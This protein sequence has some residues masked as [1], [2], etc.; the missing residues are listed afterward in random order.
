MAHGNESKFTSEMK[1]QI[2]K[3]H[4]LQKQI[5]ELT[6]KLKEMDVE[7][8]ER[9]SQLAEIYISREWKLAQ[10]FRKINTR[11]APSGSGLERMERALLS[12]LM[13]IN[14]WRNLLMLQKGH[15]LAR[16]HNRS[17]AIK[18]ETESLKIKNSHK[19]Q[20]SHFENEKQNS[21]KP[22]I[23]YVI[24][25]TAI[26]GG[27]AVICEHANRLLMRGYDVSLI[28]E[29]NF[30]KVAWFPNQRVAVLPLSQ[31]VKETY[32]ILIA[33]SWST[34][35]TTQ[36]L[37]ADRKFYFVQ[38]DESRFYS[39]RG[40]KSIWARKTYEMNFEFMTMARWIQNWLKQEFGKNS[41]YV[42]N[43]LNEQIIFPDKPIKNKRDKIRILLEGPINIPFKGME[44]AFRA[45]AG[46]DCEVWC[47]S[48]FGAPKPG[49]KCDE[50]FEK[51]PFGKMRHIY[52]SC[53]ILLKMSRIESFSYPPLEMMAC[54]GAVV[55]G[56][57]TGIDEY[58]VDGYNAL[59][60]EQGDVQGAHEALK[61]LIE[62]ESL[63]NELITNGKKTAE[64]FRWKPSIDILES[65]FLKESVK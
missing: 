62:N 4:L 63:R 41:T 58:I 43:G 56:K 15:L 8:S 12:I 61:R 18:V 29:D 11:L 22:K 26:S 37:N 31:I 16:F 3:T 49:W 14:F 60:V 38:S 9:D 6:A 1:E 13:E 28:S 48:S 52:S 19:F 5:Q 7:L 65:V 30:D 27:V 2:K 35:Y 34:A 54:G 47:V 55:V 25:G 33:T 32:D 57:V 59:L 36:Q 23:G 21:S 45:V 44:E 64:K 50:F 39:P 24:P 17:S 53:D 10:L 51:I 40:L 20:I 46:L 42:P